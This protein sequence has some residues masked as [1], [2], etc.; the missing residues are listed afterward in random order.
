MAP[1]RLIEQEWQA[2]QAYIQ[3][4]LSGVTQITGE[5]V[6]PSGSSWGGLRYCLVGSRA[7][8]FDSLS[9]AYNSATADDL[10]FVLEERLFKRLA[11]MWRFN[12]STTAFHLAASYDHLLPVNLTIR[13]GEPQTDATIPVIRAGEV[14]VPRIVQGDPVRLSGYGR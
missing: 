1:L 3:D 13:R 2:Y 7:I 9:Q 14:G 11:A 6:F 5:P 8:E 4:Q 12:Y 10:R